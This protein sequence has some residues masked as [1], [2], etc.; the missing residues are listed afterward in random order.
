MPYL[1]IDYGSKEI[2]LAIAHEENGG[3]IIVGYATLDNKGME[4]LM[5]ELREIIKKEE[6]EKLVIGLPISLKGKATSQTKETENFI[7][8]LKE[9]INIPLVTEDERLTSVL[10]KK[11]GSRNIHEESARLI[12]EGYIEKT[13]SKQKEF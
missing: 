6:I 13:Q 10:A 12:L 7:Q 8:C 9:H 11:L 4:Y 5:G 1:G 3:F 2:G